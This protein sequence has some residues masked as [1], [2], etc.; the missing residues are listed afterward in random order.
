LKQ[1]GKLLLTG[2]TGTFTGPK[3]LLLPRT[4][5]IITLLAKRFPGQVTL[6]K[7]KPGLAYHED[8]NNSAPL[9][10]VL[11]RSSDHRPVLTA[12]H[13]PEHIGIYANQSPTNSGELTID[14]VNYHH[15]LT[16]DHLAHVTRTDFTVTLQV[17]HLKS[18]DQL[19]LESIRYD[20]TA[21]NN[22]LRQPLGTDHISI[23]EGSITVRIPPFTH[24]QVLRISAAKP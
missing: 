10:E 3:A 20:E 16:S 11:A 8:A 22:T 19:T 15:D 14:L 4:E 9:H 7:T 5:D 12:T 24:Y 23:S 18:T 1:C 6:I 21:P 2:E 13:A 17:P